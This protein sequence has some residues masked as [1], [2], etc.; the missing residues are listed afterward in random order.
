MRL[1]IRMVITSASRPTN[2]CNPG[3]TTIKEN[4]REYCSISATR[5]P[6]SPSAMH[7]LESARSRA[8]ARPGEA[9]LRSIVT[10]KGRLQGGRR[11]HDGRVAV[12]E[13][14]LDPSEP[15]LRQ[16]AHELARALDSLCVPLEHRGHTRQG[17]NER[18]WVLAL[19]YTAPRHVRG[20]THLC[21]PLRVLRPNHDRSEHAL[22]ALHGADRDSA[23]RATQHPFHA[24]EVLR[25]PSHAHVCPP[26][27]AQGFHGLGNRLGRSGRLGGRAKLCHA[28]QELRNEVIGVLHRP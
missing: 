20:P 21:W 9:N 17:C 1:F 3:K 8:R 14:A 28:S 16:L 11:E 7:K 25:E 19:H 26:S 24:R 18:R 23:V 4:R 22:V 2:L 27:G 10:A 6:Q 5:L 15:T 13:Q 12:L